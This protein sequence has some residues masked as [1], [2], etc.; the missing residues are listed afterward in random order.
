MPDVAS[1]LKALDPAL[2]E[3][4]RVIRTIREHETEL[5]ALGVAKLW[6]CGSLAR[7]DAGKRSDVD[8][9]ISVRRAQEFS[10]LD[11]AGVRVELCEILGR[12]IPMW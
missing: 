10:V 11:L 8:A 5:R 6:L 7:G 4:D 9:L 2:R 3:R 12:A 1:E